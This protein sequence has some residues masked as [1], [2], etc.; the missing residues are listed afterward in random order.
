MSKDLRVASCRVCKQSTEDRSN[1]YS[2]VETH[3]K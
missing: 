3:R 1:Y 2:D